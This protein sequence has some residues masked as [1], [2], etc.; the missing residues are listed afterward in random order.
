LKKTIHF[1][2]KTAGIGWDRL[3]TLPPNTCVFATPTG[4]SIGLAAQ[5]TNVMSKNGTFKM[6]HHVARGKHGPFY[7]KSEKVIVSDYRYF[8]WG[9]KI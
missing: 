2:L 9:F 6:F 7:Q 5:A 8:F 3:V 4:L 1:F